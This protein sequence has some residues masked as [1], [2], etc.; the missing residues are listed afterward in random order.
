M[1]HRVVEGQLQWRVKW[2]NT[3]VNTEEYAAY[4]GEVEKVK[5]TRQTDKNETEMLVQWKM[6]WATRTSIHWP[7]IKPAICPYA[8]TVTHAQ[9][10]YHEGSDGTVVYL[11]KW[12]NLTTPLWTPASVTMEY[13]DETTLEQVREAPL[14]DPKSAKRKKHS[15]KRNKD[16]WVPKYWDYTAPWKKRSINYKPS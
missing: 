13:L 6:E 14:L 2:A 11:C 8:G 9:F 4:K 12:S 10:R 3:W 16:I 1:N 15:R 7:Q 5:E